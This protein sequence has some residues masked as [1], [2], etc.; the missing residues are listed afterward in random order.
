MR[1]RTQRTFCGYDS[2]PPPKK[3]SLPPHH[4]TLNVNGFNRFGLARESILGP[5]GFQLLRDPDGHPVCRHHA[6]LRPGEISLILR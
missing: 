1:K 5:A 3:F 4:F 6:D 2:P